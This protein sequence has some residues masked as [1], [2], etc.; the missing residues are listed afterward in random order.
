MFVYVA[1]YIGAWIE[2]DLLLHPSTIKA[3]APYIGAWIEM[4]ARFEVYT[5]GRSHLT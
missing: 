2:M 1:P 4:I 5:V 3:V